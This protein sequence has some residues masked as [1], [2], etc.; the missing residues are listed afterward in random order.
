MVRIAAP[1][2]LPIGPTSLAGLMGVEPTGTDV[3][4]RRRHHADSSPKLCRSLPA[5]TP[6][7][8]GV[9]G[10]PITLVFSTRR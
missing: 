2:E 1:I 3:T 7:Y 10:W 8:H 9:Y 4:S 5:V 6:T